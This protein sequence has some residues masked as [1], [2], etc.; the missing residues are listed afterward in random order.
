M[1]CQVFCIVGSEWS[2]FWYQIFQC[3]HI[4]MTVQRSRK[5]VTM[6]T[7]GVSVWLLISQ[8]ARF[9]LPYVLY[10]HNANQRVRLLISQLV[11]FN[12]D[13]GSKGAENCYNA[14]TRG[15]FTLFK[16][17][18]CLNASQGEVSVW[19]LIHHSHSIT[20]VVWWMLKRKREA[21]MFELTVRFQVSTCYKI[22]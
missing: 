3:Q 14:I 20:L 18:S 8:L 4:V 2:F 11:C 1:L 22:E 15:K 10:C 16:T 7:R 19:L 6:L 13:D 17:R 9:I 21:S 5:V 12:I